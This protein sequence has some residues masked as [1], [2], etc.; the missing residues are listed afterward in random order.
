MRMIWLTLLLCALCAPASAQ[1][2]C[3]LARAVGADYVCQQ[4]AAQPAP[5]EVFDG[6]LMIGDSICESIYNYD[7]IAPLDVEAVV[8]QS[9]HSAYL[10]RNVRRDGRD[11]TMVELAGYLQPSRLLI[12]LGSNGL[13]FKEVGA[14]IEEYHVLLDMLLEAA[15]DTQIY[16]VSLTP[17]RTKVLERY[18]GLTTANVIAC[19][20]ALYALAQAHGVHYI[21]VATTLFDEAGLELDMACAAG[22]GQ[23]LT[24]E[25]AQRMAQAIRMQVTQ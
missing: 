23:H 21:D 6:A 17:T 1:E 2:A 3:P 10:T 14:V 5:D 8:G 4:Q 22:D 13:D 16:V 9:A 20:Q 11:F 19:N 24:L 7:V 18:P 12:M 15:P 25:G